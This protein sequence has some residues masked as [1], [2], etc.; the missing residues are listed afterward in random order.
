MTGNA[1]FFNIIGRLAIPI[2][3][4]IFGGMQNLHQDLRNSIFKASNQY[5]ELY[6]ARHG[7]FNIL[8]MNE[9]V[10]LASVYVP[11]NFLSEGI[12]LANERQYLMVLGAPGV[13][14]STFLCQMGL[15][16]L[17]GTKPV[18][19][20]TKIPV[21][22]ELK[23]LTDNSINLETIKAHIIREFSICGFPDAE[24]FTNQ[25]LQEGKLLILLDGLDEIPNRNLTEA[26]NQI[27]D[28][29]N[30]YHQNRFIISCRTAAYPA[31]RR[32][33]K[34]FTSVVIAD[35]NDN[36]IEQ[37]IHKWFSSEADEQARTQCWESLQEPNNAAAKKLAKTPLLL[38]FL[39]LV[40]Q[41]L[42]SFPENRTVLYRK[43]LRILLEEWPLSKGSHETENPP[44][45]DTDQEEKLLSEIAYINFESNKLFFLQSD[46]VSQIRTFLT[47]NLNIS[48]N[49]YP[50][51]IL[52]AIVVQKGLLVKGE[53]DAY[54]FSHL[55]LQEYL[56]AQYIH[57]HHQIDKLVTEHLTDKRWKEVFL[58]VGGLMENGADDLLL[59]MERQAQQYINTPK[60]QA[61]L[62]WTQE[63]TGE[64]E[65]NYQPVVK[66]A[67][68][69]AYAY[70][71]V[72]TYT[73]AYRLAYGIGYGYTQ[74][75]AYANIYDN[76]SAIANIYTDSPFDSY[77]KIY[78]IAN[79]YT[80]ANVSNISLASAI[81][82]T[83]SIRDAIAN[84]ISH[85]SNLQKLNIIIN[86]NLT[87]L[88]TNLETLQS[89]VPSD[90]NSIEELRVFVQNFQSL[91]QT[92]T[93]EWLQAFSLTLEIVNLSLEEAK[94]LGDYLYANQL[95]IQCKQAAVKVSPQTWE[96]IEARM[97]LVP[98]D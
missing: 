90:Q 18:F 11:V 91:I 81:Y 16:V 35:F 64:S 73:I 38:T 94:A 52:N 65:G 75:Y 24:R 70:V 51:A 80:N 17:T 82:N 48:Q 49:L 4:I 12:Q 76:A 39:C 79:V 5:E 83:N 74:A 31:Y 97:L 37:L 1:P 55:T 42:Q 21:F 6:R 67:A 46:V 26:I 29:V 41:R 20:D 56:T 57:D 68:A 33:F 89:Q 72:N 60:L 36:Q 9:P 95:I 84:T 15:E 86:I 62:N 47:T 96:A 43:A 23:K 44:Y 71:I 66:R 8:T 92:F 87:E 13:G 25:A 10:N 88:I 32:G 77:P 85:F 40:Y 98:N 27:S 34:R 22:V 45:L 58:M 69:I 50:E 59:L 19:S 54:S 2:F 3:E 28:F 63:V 53:D 61:L 30:M 7:I 14:K 78:D 93:Q